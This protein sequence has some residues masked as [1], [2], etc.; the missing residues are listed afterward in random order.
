MNSEADLERGLKGLAG[1]VEI[2]D[3]PP[4]EVRRSLRRH[5]QRRTGIVTGGC[6]LAAMA[7][8]VLLVAANHDQPERVGA[9][10]SGTSSSAPQA[11]ATEDTVYDPGAY[12]YPRTAGGAIDPA[13]VPAVSYPTDFPAEIPRPD[14]YVNDVSPMYL[15]TD[16]VGWQISDVTG[17]SGG[18]SACRRYAAQFDSW[19]SREVLDEIDVVY[20]RRF[21]SA[22]WTVSILCTNDG[23]FLAD[24]MKP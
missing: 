11:A 14:T 15:N 23:H 17:K 20:A 24:V 22:D 5:R 1:A 16:V 12:P 19:P 18:V 7:T 8:G 21:T 6:V 13:S 4:S 2:L 9:S 3:V 10:A